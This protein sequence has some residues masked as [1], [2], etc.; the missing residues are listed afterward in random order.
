MMNYGQMKV[1]GAPGAPPA[2]GQQAAWGQAAG[3]G[4]VVNPNGVG[5]A[6][7]MGNGT[8]VRSYPTIASAGP[9]LA[10]GCPVPATDMTTMVPKRVLQKHSQTVVWYSEKMEQ[11]PVTTATAVQEI[12]HPTICGAM[13]QADVCAPAIANPCGTGA[14]GV[15]AVAATSYLPSSILPGGSVSQTRINF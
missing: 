14:C 8:V 7:A 13:P 12:V 3:Q 5:S 9:A 2:W 11:H 4:P 1:A 15:G 10:A 6:V